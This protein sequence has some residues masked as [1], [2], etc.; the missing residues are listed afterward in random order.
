MNLGPPEKGVQVKMC[1]LDKMK[2]A[3]AAV[4]TLGIAC[5]ASIVA[6]GE[7]S[8]EERVNREFSIEK[9]TLE[10]EGRANYLKHLQ[11]IESGFSQ[12]QA[13]FR[14]AIARLQA[15]LDSDKD[16]TEEER[17]TYAKYIKGH[18]ARLRVA[19]ELLKMTQS[20]ISRVQALGSRKLA[21]LYKRKRDLLKE[22][23]MKQCTDEVKNAEL[24]VTQ[25]VPAYTSLNQS[26][27]IFDPDTDQ[28][29]ST[30][31]KISYLLLYA[32][33]DEALT[34]MESALLETAKEGIAGGQDIQLFKDQLELKRI[35]VSSELNASNDPEI[36]R[37]KLLRAQNDLKETEVS[38]HEGQ[39]EFAKNLE[40]YRALIRNRLLMRSLLPD[41]NGTSSPP[42]Q[43]MAESRD[44][45]RSS[46]A[47]AVSPAASPIRSGTQSANE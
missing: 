19:D 6:A 3:F 32:P 16:M 31:D 14:D 15:E 44:L 8:L 35:G 33:A 17:E 9:E 21:A 13:T 24:L 38:H 7:I 11:R 18:Q 45:K 42:C 12:E 46:P 34:A 22:T 43:A 36:Q 29:E 2:F 10:I 26:L 20:E 47:E 30:S 37:E 39:A 25:I 40:R 4:T 23:V 27:Q 28:F 5:N 41:Q 1:I